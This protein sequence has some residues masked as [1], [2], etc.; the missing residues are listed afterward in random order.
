MA[1]FEFDISAFRGSSTL[2]EGGTD[3]TLLP[4]LMLLFTFLAVGDGEEAPVI[5][6]PRPFNVV[7]DG[8][9]VFGE[10]VPRGVNTLDVGA[11]AEIGATP[12]LGALP[13]TGEDARPLEGLPITPDELVWYLTLL[14]MLLRDP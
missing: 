5:A 1:L 7:G 4:L 8:L 12:P 6:V 9:F 14:P 13:L 11:T 10:I 3:A 2:D